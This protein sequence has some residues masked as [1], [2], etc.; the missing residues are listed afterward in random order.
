MFGDV[1]VFDKFYDA[2]LVKDGHR[3][4]N[5]VTGEL[6][7]HGRPGLFG[8]VTELEWHCNRVSDPDRKP[9]VWLYGEKGTVGSRTSWLNHILTYND[10]PQEKKDQFKDIKLNLRR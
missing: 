3:K 4:I 5:R 8:H 6:D 1:L 7:E 10:L 2:L 9:I